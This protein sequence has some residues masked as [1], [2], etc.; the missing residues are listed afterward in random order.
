V[1]A[2]CL[3]MRNAVDL[4]YACLQL[5]IELLSQTPSEYPRYCVH[6]GCF[7][8]MDCQEPRSSCA[9]QLVQDAS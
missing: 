2:V 5:Q 1:V 6:P 3:R 4:D 9:Q 8:R 7:D